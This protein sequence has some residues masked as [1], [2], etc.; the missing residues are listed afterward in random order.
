[1]ILLIDL[2]WK[3]DSL[4]ASEF[5]APIANIVRKSGDELRII[6][7]L[8]VNENAISCADRIILCGT[9]L[10]DNSFSENPQAFDWIKGCEKPLLG[11]C[12]GLQAISF[13]FGG[14]IIECCEIG[15]QKITI[16]KSDVLFSEKNDFE[17]YCLHNF[18]IRL[19]Q[20]FDILA[21]SENCIQAIK[22]KS[23]TIYGVMFHPEVRCEWVV[24]NF[25]SHI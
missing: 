16:R 7:Y 8:D 6:H 1:M 14:K 24:R 12:A 20:D 23:R 10:M 11:I 2:C 13:S 25:L 4:S 5:V 17:A 22:H 15:M 21:E 3:K 9:A 18:S 19:P